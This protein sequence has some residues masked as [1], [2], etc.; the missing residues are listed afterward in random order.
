MDRCE[1][2]PCCGHE[3]GDCNG[4]LYGSDE[5]IKAAYLKKISSPD[6]DE[7]YDER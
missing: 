5:Q 7:Y 6:Y 2:A 4:K 3:V 1:D